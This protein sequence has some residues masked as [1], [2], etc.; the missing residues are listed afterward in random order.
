MQ[1]AALQL[2]MVELVPKGCSRFANRRRRHNG[3][4]QDRVRD[5]QVVIVSDEWLLTRD[6][7]YLGDG[8]RYTR[9]IKTALA[10]PCGVT[11]RF[12][13]LSPGETVEPGRTAATGQSTSGD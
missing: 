13:K 7:V 5:E 3:Q 10:W 11:L 8:T 2:D 12:K 1:I 6:G 4:Q 9:R